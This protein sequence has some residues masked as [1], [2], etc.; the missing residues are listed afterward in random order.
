M[1][2]LGENVVYLGVPELLVFRSAIKW[3]ARQL[4]Q[5]TSLRPKSTK[6]VQLEFGVTETR[7]RAVRSFGFSA[8]LK[9]F[10]TLP[11]FHISHLL[12]VCFL[13]SLSTLDTLVHT[14]VYHSQR[15][16]LSAHRQR[17]CPGD[18]TDRKPCHLIALKEISASTISFLL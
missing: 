1:R 7:P 2:T 6:T 17:D 14:I 3:S 4:L 10:R 11:R 16:Q 12:A 18:C 5:S 13:A 15:R 9:L 8:Y